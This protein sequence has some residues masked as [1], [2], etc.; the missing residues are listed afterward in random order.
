MAGDAAQ[1]SPPVFSKIGQLMF[2]QSANAGQ[3]N[4]MFSSNK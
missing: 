4:E 2:I 1:Q 3:I